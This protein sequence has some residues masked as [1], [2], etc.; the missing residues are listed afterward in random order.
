MAEEVLLTPLSAVAGDV[1]EDGGL[2]CGDFSLG[3]EEKEAGEEGVDLLGVG[4]V[5]EVGGEGGG[6]VDWVGRRWEDG[7]GVLGAEGLAGEADEAATHAVGEAV[8]A[9]SRVVDGAGLS[10]ACVLG[11]SKPSAILFSSQHG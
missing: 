11:S 1:G 3:E 10:G 9:T 5:V 8:V 7:L 2:A 6:D 4:E